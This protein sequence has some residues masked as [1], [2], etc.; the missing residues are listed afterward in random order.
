MWATLDFYH[1]EYLLG[2]SPLIPDTSF[3]RWE[4]S[5]RKRIDRRNVVDEPTEELRQ[6]VCAVSEALFTQ[7]QSES[8]SA[9]SGFSNDGYSN[10]F[11]DQRKE[12]KDFDKRVNAI[13]ANHLD[14]TEWWNALVFQGVG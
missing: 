3:P 7:A 5:A 11:F 12:K 8:L 1:N 10:T 14:G 6:C 13:I 4:Q 2:D 9:V